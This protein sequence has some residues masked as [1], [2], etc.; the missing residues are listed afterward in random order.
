MHAV[1]GCGCTL[2]AFT[3]YVHW[4]GLSSGLSI[5][6]STGLF[7]DV[8]TGLFTD[9]STDLSTGLFTDLSTGLSTSFFTDLST[10]LSTGAASI[11]VMIT[12]LQVIQGKQRSSSYCLMN[13][14]YL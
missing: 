14:L 6:L 3:C 7:T 5:A 11:V 12:V 9:V 13:A 10:S 2:P 4:H 1:C 8:S